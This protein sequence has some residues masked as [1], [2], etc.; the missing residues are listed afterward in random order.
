M[1]VGASVTAMNPDVED[2]VEGCRERHKWSW[3][4]DIID[5]CMNSGMLCSL[6]I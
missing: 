4:P 6:I 2:S 3:L 1:K 5:H